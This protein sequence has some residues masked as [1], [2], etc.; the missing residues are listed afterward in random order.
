[1]VSRLLFGRLFCTSTIESSAFWF[2]LS[3]SLLLAH[4]SNRSSRISSIMLSS[5]MLSYSACELSAW[6]MLLGLCFSE[7]DVQT[8]M[9][10]VCLSLSTV[11][12]P[13]LHLTIVTR[14]GS[15][16]EFS[17]FRIMVSSVPLTSAYDGM[18][19]LSAGASSIL[20][21]VWAC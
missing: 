5:S 16:T 7:G 8:T 19:S 12:V 1:M 13:T 3:V 4:S 20:F 9:G 11:L 18:R 6:S 21:E 17:Y 2:Y 15:S 10:G 14:F